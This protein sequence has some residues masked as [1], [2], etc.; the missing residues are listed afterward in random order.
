MKNKSM[1]TTLTLLMLL[2]AD[3]VLLALPLSAE[4]LAVP[5][6]S[7]G[8]TE[9][10]L[11]KKKKIIGGEIFNL[12]T[13][14]D[15]K[16]F[17]VTL[18][19]FL[20]AG[21]RNRK[22]K[23]EEMILSANKA[24]TSNSTVN[25]SVYENAKL[26]GV[27]IRVFHLKPKEGGADSTVEITVI[28]EENDDSRNEPSVR[29]EPI[30]EKISTHMFYLFKP[31][32]RRLKA[33]MGT[34]PEEAAAWKAIRAEALLL[35]ESGGNLVA[36]RPGGAVGIRDG[37]EYWKSNSLAVRNHGAE[38]YNAAKKEDFAAA[39]LSYRAMT[40]S[41]NACHKA[42]VILGAPPVLVPFGAGITD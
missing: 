30:E 16:A 8:M 14:L 6:F 12:K 13:A 20:G 23:N 28:R 3:I 11:A 7:K 31:S 26:P 5:D 32:Y 38:L 21:W 19:K 9:V 33:L 18:R 37:K 4:E 35:A 27:D 25:L 42:S 22:L 36:R 10:T 15:S 24:R 1:T 39:K 34:E 40:N 29:S 2:L 17:S 41:C